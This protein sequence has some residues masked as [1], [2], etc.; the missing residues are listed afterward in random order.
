MCRGYTEVYERLVGRPS[1]PD[2]RVAPPQVRVPFTATSNGSRPGS[3]QRS[4]TRT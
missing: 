4:G 1:R 3:V 2:D